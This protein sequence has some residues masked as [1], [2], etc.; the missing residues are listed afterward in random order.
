M[1]F[2]YTLNVFNN[3]S[4]EPESDSKAL[5]RGHLPPCHQP[6]S[7]AKQPSAFWVARASLCQAGI[8]GPST[9]RLPSIAGQV[10]PRENVQDKKIKERPCFPKCKYS[11]WLKCTRALSG[12]GSMSMPKWRNSSD[13]EV[14]GGLGGG[15]SLTALHIQKQAN[16]SH[17]S[18]SPGVKSQARNLFKLTGKQF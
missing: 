12:R 6:L 1:S 2:L 8:T 7:L 4:S 11:I 10:P 3:W 9:P 14:L 17:L 5:P 18:P 16:R 15:R 13:S